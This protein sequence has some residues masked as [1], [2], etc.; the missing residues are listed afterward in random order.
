MILNI[1]FADINKDDK[2]DL[3]LGGNE[4]DLLPQFSR[5]D[6]S[7]GH[8]LLNDGKA[9]FTYK[10]SNESG[11]ELRGQIRDLVP[12]KGKDKNY[13]LFLQNNEYPLLYQLRKN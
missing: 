3:V 13:L 5:L 7:F 1:A 10:N 11:L 12:L 6:A 2:T 8:V 4:F 9:N